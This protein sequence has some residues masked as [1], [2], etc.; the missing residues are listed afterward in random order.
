[1]LTFLAVVGGVAL[2]L[3]GVKLRNIIEARLRGGVDK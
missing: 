1:M 3:G 2:F